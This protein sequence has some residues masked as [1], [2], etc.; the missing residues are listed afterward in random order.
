MSERPEDGVVNP[1]GEVFNYP[2]MY[3]ADGSVLPTSLTIGPSLTILAN[4]ERIA[5]ALLNKLHLTPTEN[6]E[7]AQA[8][9]NQA[10]EI[11]M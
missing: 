5:H 11:T 2:G 7:V 6:N 8:L 9:R 4:A 1:D 10:R 3:I